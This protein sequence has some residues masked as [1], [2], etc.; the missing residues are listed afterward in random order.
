MHWN[1]VSICL[2]FFS[3][4]L[5]TPP[6]VTLEKKEALN[7]L[8]RSRVKRSL[9]EECVEL[10]GCSVGDVYSYYGYRR[11]G[12]AVRNILFINTNQN[13]HI[14]NRILKNSIVVDVR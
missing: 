5:G 9:W 4:S 11:D 14:T 8:T 12:L 13:K 1:T 10:Y 3:I 6:N 7:F 2:N